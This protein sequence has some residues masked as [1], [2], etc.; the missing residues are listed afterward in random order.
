M[1][2]FR[3]LHT[4]TWA[5]TWFCNLK[6]EY[7]LFFIYLF[8]NE[9]ASAVGLYELPIRN[10]SFETGLDRDVIQKGLEVF[11]K[12]DKV[13]Y[14]FETSLVW[15]KNMHKYQTNSSS[16]LMARIAADI[17]AAP[18]CR[19]K[20]DAIAWFRENTNLIHQ[21][22]GID[23]VS[24]PNPQ[25]A[26]ETET[27]TETETERDT[28]TE[29]EDE[30]KPAAAASSENPFT[31]YENNI[32]PMTPIIAEKIKLAEKDYPAAWILEAIKIAVERNKR[33]WR[34]IEGILNSWQ[35]EGKDNGK[36]RTEKK[37][38]AIIPRETELMR[39]QRLG[40]VGVGNGAKNL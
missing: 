34:Y 13:L 19:L 18:N 33:N 38:E 29:T 31:I 37:Q 25:N 20:E 30:Q 27:E 5:D 8:S 4:R 22:Y 1:A 39:R 3:Q 32:G 14:D 36:S 15:V 40:L 16:K 11:I 26:D 6:P 10:M 12:A 7:K 24:I 2:D 35:T 23:R 17:K 9:R 28:D 21:R